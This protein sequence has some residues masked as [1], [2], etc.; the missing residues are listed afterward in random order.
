MEILWRSVVAKGCVTDEYS[1]AVIGW[2]A[3]SV[4]SKIVF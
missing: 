4:K 1:G 2:F 3:N